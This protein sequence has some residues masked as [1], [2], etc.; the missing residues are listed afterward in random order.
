[1]LQQSKAGSR[2]L[3]ALSQTSDF[4]IP[5]ETQGGFHGAQSLTLHQQE[6]PG[7]F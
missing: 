3:D 2:V 6:G 1:M 7:P 4:T 5:A